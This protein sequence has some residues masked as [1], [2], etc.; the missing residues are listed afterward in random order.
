MADAMKRKR[1]VQI[2]LLFFT[3]V[4]CGTAAG[5][6]LAFSHDLPQIRFLESYK[7]S[8]ITRIY[9]AD[10]VLLSELYA[11]NRDPVPFHIIPEYL[12]KA[13]II[14]E[15]RKFY[16]HSGMDIKGIVRAVI[17]DVLALEP[18]EGASTITMQLSKTLFLDSRKTIKR[19]LKEAILAFQLERRYTK[20][21]LLGLYM[22]QIY[23]G[24]GAYGIKAAARIYFNKPVQELTLSECA[25]IAG[26]PKAPSQYSPLV[27]PVLALK[28]RNIVLKQMVNTGT[29]SQV[30]FQAAANEP[31][32]LAEN[33]KQLIRAPYFVDH[34]VKGL[35]TEI[36]SSILYKG[37]LSIYTTLDF[38]LQQEAEYTIQSHMAA[39][40]GRMLHH[41]ITNPDPQAAML[42]LDISAGS[43]LC[44]VGGKSY[45][46]SRLNRAV[47]VRRQAG[48]AF[49]P[50]V[51][52]CA[53][54]NGIPQNTLITDMPAS[55]PGNRKGSTWKPENFSGRYG[56]E[57]TL[58]KALAQS[59]NIPAVKLLEMLGTGTVMQFARDLGISGPLSPDLSLA[60]GTSAVSLM[61]LVAAYAVFPNRGNYIRPYGIQEIQDASGRIIWRGK[62]HK[63]VAM[64]RKGAA[65]ITDMLKGAV[66]EGT[67]KKARNHLNGPLAGKSGTTIEYRDSLFIGFSPA[68]ITGVWV[69]DDAYRS[70]GEGETGART[71]LPIWIDFMQAALQREST[72]YFDFPDDVVKIRIDP[73]TGLPVSA[74]NVKGVDVL[75]I[76]GTEPEKKG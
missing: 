37:G 66:D 16:T 51:Y 54:E 49:Q 53:A 22:N 38:R 26:M 76:K 28:R 43:I 32:C 64:S 57:M 75:F 10:H 4:V 33:K 69:G 6:L 9:S 13:L 8:A 11:E 23:F 19:K 72:Q 44:M 73:V 46:K 40:T 18:L 20:D 25:L 65:I 12:K 62:P 17:K 36:G 2:I 42:T 27:N 50:I 68:I 15:D 45:D 48:S 58:R 24:S 29:I 39:L 60:L 21:E 41:K 56:G 30:Q 67:G 63:Q 1:Q 35:E 3:A 7:P 59:K 55:F 52:A 5:V 71:A 14:T 74:E 47:T 70:L 61:E 31:L 34:I